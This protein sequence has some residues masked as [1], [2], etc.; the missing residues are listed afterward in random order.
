MTERYRRGAAASPYITYFSDVP[1][2]PATAFCR[3]D[4]CP[5]LELHLA[6]PG[7]FIAT[8]PGWHI[9]LPGPRRLL[10]EMILKYTPGHEAVAAEE[11]RS[12]V[13]ADYGTVEYRPFLRALLRLT[14][15]RKLERV[16]LDA[17]RGYAYR[18][19][20]PR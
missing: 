12:A 3:R 14:A 17:A 6:H 19:V 13:Q 16:R 20:A 15:A 1:D 5:A 18:R 4:D 11:L 9:P 8:R 2:L 10:T 7:V